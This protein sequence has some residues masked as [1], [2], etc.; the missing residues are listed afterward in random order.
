MGQTK[1]VFVY[2]LIAEETLEER[3]Y[4]RQVQ[5]QALAASVVDKKDMRGRVYTTKELSIKED[6]VSRGAEDM[7]DKDIRKIDPCL[8]DVLKDWSLCLSISDHSKLFADSTT[9][10][11][12]S[13]QQ[14]V[15]NEMRLKT[16]DTCRYL[17]ASEDN[18]EKIKAGDLYFSDG[19]TLVPPYAPVLEKALETE[20]INGMLEIHPE[21]KPIIF[22]VTPREN[23]RALR[24]K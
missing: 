19:S 1:S 22:P 6:I 7:S 21:T 3:L 18:I 2:R 13:D 16:R 20:L 15:Q 24:R 17:L 4:R 11:D 8:V 23:N 9:E 12:S 14:I 10:L 5:K